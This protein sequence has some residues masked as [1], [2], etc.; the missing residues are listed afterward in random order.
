MT[1]ARAWGV[2]ALGILVAALGGVLVIAGIGTCLGGCAPSTA[3]VQGEAQLGAW[4]ADDG[5][6]VQGG[7][8]RAEIDACRDSMRR[9]FCGADGGVMVDSGACANVTL[10]TGGRP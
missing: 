8:T 6:C 4:T 7:T 10:S 2:L 5:V 1:N 3:L 9:F